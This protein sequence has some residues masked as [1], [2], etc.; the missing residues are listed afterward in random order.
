MRVDA[1]RFRRR[2]CAGVAA[3]L[4]VPAAL[5][6]C[7]SASGSSGSGT[8]TV[9]VG[10][11]LGMTGELSTY[12]DQML[13][14]V[15]DSAAYWNTQSAKTHVRVSIDL[16]D[17]QSTSAGAAT[18][19][20]KA[21]SVDG[22]NVVIS[23]GTAP[24]LEVG[25][26][27]QR[28]NILNLDVGGNSP[29]VLEAGTTTLHTNPNN[30]D[31]LPAMIAF[32]KSKNATQRVAVAYSDDS[33]GQ[34]F[35]ARFVAYW[36]KAV[37]T[38]IV[39]NVGYPAGASSYLAQASQIRAANP[40]NL[41][42]LGF[43]VD[44][45]HF[46]S[47]LVTAGYKGFVLEENNL[48][49]QY[50]SLS[51]SITNGQYMVQGAIA[52]GKP[53]VAGAALTTMYNKKHGTTEVPFLVSTGFD[54]VTAIVEGASAVHAHGGRLTGSALVSAVEKAPDMPGA[55]NPSLKFT[56]LGT[57]VGDWAFYVIKAGKQVLVQEYTPA[58]L[59]KLPKFD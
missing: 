25:K 14:G 56:S 32:L 4:L 15:R 16:Q 42:L 17:S 27:A 44:A 24:T 45:V 13:E 38:N 51:P 41:V 10:A 55:L 9:K 31:S 47:Q 53:S 20:Q 50:T 26:L 49:P 5:A 59:A 40:Q 48:I 22:D 46:I 6:A 29:G 19:Y 36:K 39:A 3:G 52:S 37:G 21:V 11:I 7:G 54:G 43:G 8:T 23:D 57:V 33:F 1:S 35:Q 58:Q 34:P 30:I 18:A 2:T 12:S 28:A